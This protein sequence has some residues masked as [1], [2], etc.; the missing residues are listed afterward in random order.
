MQFSKLSRDPKQLIIL[1][2]ETN[3]NTVNGLINTKHDK[4]FNEQTD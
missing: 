2:A 1:D 3:D 4:T